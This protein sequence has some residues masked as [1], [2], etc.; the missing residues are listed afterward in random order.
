MASTT[1]E[2]KKGA[3]IA[4]PRRSRDMPVTPQTAKRTAPTGGVISPKTRFRQ[5]TIP[6]WTG[7]IPRW[8]AMGARTGVTMTRAGAVSMGIPMRSSRMLMSRRISQGD[9][10]R[11][12]IQVDQELGD[13]VRRDDPGE[14]LRHGDE[15]HHH[16]RF[17]PC[18]QKDIRQISQ[19]Q[20]SIE[21]HADQGRINAGHTGRLGGA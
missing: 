17:Q 13:L 20:P 12:E 18:L 19:I 11:V 10:V 9:V 6:M 15:E 1:R 14:R 16:P 2:T 4:L 5:M 7:S 21:K 8:M 3:Q